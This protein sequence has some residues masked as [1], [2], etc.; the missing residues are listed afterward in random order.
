MRAHQFEPNLVGPVFPQ[1]YTAGQTAVS[2][3][4]AATFQAQSFYLLKA[5]N[6]SSITVESGG[7]NGSPA[8]SDIV[9][10]LR[11]NVV[12]TGLPNIT[13]GGLIATATTTTLAAGSSNHVFT[14]SPAVALSAGVQYHIVFKNVNGTPASNNTSFRSQSL[15]ENYTPANLG[16][17][18]W[19]TTNSGTSWNQSNSLM[20]AFRLFFDDATQTTIRETVFAAGS[21]VG[22]IYAARE[23]GIKF[24]SPN[25]TM[26]IV[27]VNFAMNKQGSPTQSIGCKIYQGTTLVATSANTV[28]KSVFNGTTNRFLFVFSTPVA[29]APS[30]VYRIVVYEN[31]Q[32]DI[33]SNRYDLYCTTL[34][35][36][37]PSTIFDAVL[38]YFNVT[39]TDTTTVC[40]LFN[41]ITDS[42]LINDFVSPVTD[43][44]SA[45]ELKT[46]VTKMVS[47]SSV[48]G[49]Y[50]GSDRW[51][52]PAEANVRKSTQYKANST[53]NNKTGTLIGSV[54][55][56]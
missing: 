44:I 24:T 32:S 53:S 50:D 55:P 27:G 10:E 2:V 21:S 46:G 25:T 4:T 9:C 35:S 38:T 29:L 42:D 51:T 5:K 17:G 6:L 52:D 49:T 8:N 7:I 22:G 1:T 3:S 33:I 40:P 37:T 16:T 30:T 28:D 26:N 19:N 34:N 47:G 54:L 56:V 48:T 13:G 12:A 31:T 43:S 18:T 41:L 36:A 20:C 23:A 11:S 45:G 15:T 14:F 39:W